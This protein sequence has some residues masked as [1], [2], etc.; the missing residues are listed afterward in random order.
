MNT[1]N[2]PFRHLRNTNMRAS[3]FVV[4]MLLGILAA[5]AMQWNVP[6]MDEQQTAMLNELLDPFGIAAA[7]ELESE[8]SLDPFDHVE[9]VSS[10][11][12]GENIRLHD[13]W[14]DNDQ[15]DDDWCDGDFLMLNLSKR[16][17]Y[18]AVCWG[19]EANPGPVSIAA[20]EVKYLGGVT[21]ED[22][23]VRGVTVPAVPIP[24]VTVFANS[25]MHVIEFE[26]SGTPDDPAATAGNGVFDFARDG[27]GIADFDIT[28]A[29]QVNRAASLERDWEMTDYEEWTGEN[30]AGWNFTL[31][32]QNVDYDGSSIW[33]MTDDGSVI[34]NIAFTFHLGVTVDP[35]TD[36]AIPWWRISVV[37]EGDDEWGLVEESLVQE[38][39]KTWSGARV[40]FDFKYDQS[41]DG[42][43]FSESQNGG[44]VKLMVESVIV[45]GTFMP[46]VVAE[47][48]DAT[49][50]QIGAGNESMIYSAADENEVVLGTADVRGVNM[51]SGTSVSWSHDFT[52]VPDKLHW[53]DNADIGTVDANGDTQWEN[54]P[55]IF[56]LHASEAFSGEDDKEEG[57]VSLYI[58]LG[59]YIFPA[60]DRIFHDPGYSGAISLIQ[61]GGALITNALVGGQFVVI[62][63]MGALGTIF[64]S[65][66]RRR[67]R[68]ILLSHSTPKN[69]AASGLPVMMDLPP[70]S[71]PAGGGAY[72][73]QPPP[74]GG[75]W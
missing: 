33:W 51:V 56:Q 23:P 11:I 28:A 31:Q 72:P 41:I 12:V 44:D 57:N 22:F 45:R 48:L 40:G 75:G 67:H 14:D 8:A 73:G 49:V 36:E 25:L 21:V 1:Q 58:A 37:N 61:L 71:T 55:V 52:K 66:R 64:I 4:L 54:V 17:S 53:V 35:V 3:S 20:M 60:A 30:S 29:E 43:D 2:R 27:S 15:D 5:P 10:A 39:D 68:R 26:D 69:P 70:S 65:V 6:L 16:F 34:E 7:A 50:Q 42:W 19:S 13:P 74:G 18:L 46:N 47:F 63:L 32:T 9:V 59:G 62:L 38:A 24:V